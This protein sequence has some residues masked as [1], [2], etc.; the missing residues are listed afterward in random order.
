MSPYFIPNT[1]LD[2][3]TASVLVLKW[4]GLENSVFLP[5]L[6]F[7]TTTYMYYTKMSW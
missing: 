4:S 7:N 6:S 5:M 3:S 1:A 2:K